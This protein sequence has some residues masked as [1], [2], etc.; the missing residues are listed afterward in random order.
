M[1]RVNSLSGSNIEVSHRLVRIFEILPGLATW[2]T[3]FLPI[4][5][6]IY[7]PVVV[8]YFIIAFDLF[9]L[10]KSFRMSSALLVGHRRLRIATQLDWV[11]RLKHLET[12]MDGGGVQEVEQAIVE[13]KREQSFF[14]YFSRVGRRKHEKLQQLQV[15]LD[16]LRNT[17]V[18]QKTIKPSDV[19]HVVI[20]ATYNET[21][22]TLRPSLEALAQVNYDLSKIWLVIAHEERGGDV[23]R[24]RIATLK[25]EFDGKFARLMS[26]EHP[27]GIVG[28]EKG[29]G[30]NI[31]YA[32][33]QVLKAIRKDKIN[34]K[35]VVITTLDADHRPDPEY[36]NHLTYSFVT[37][38]TPK[39]YSYQPIPMFFNNIWH[40]PAPMRVIAT[41]NSFW[42]IIN[43]VRPHL[44]RNFAS[45]SQPLEALVDT[46]FWATWSVVE[47]GH[48]YWRSYYRYN[49]QYR[50]EP[51]Y[52][53][54]YQD[55]TLASG[56]FKTFKNQYL[57]M[58]RWAYGVSDVPYVAIQNMRHPKIPK[59]SRTVHFW[60]LF[61]GHFSWATA[62][63][64][65]T[66]VA[67]MPLFLN[68]SFKYSVLAH[69]LP[70][71]ASQIMTIAMVGLFL[72]IWL[73]II[74]LPQRPKSKKKIHG[75]FMILQW[76]LLPIVALGFGALAA[77]DA[78]TR[79]M[80]GKYLGFRV[81]E[82][83]VKE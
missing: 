68:A 57:Q 48:Q 2:I 7:A 25:Q 49:G 34:I 54:I 77:I 11:A 43:S 29:K 67:W 44:L 62:P 23:D 73:S 59:S 55:A 78:Q 14:W 71:I 65:L 15:E 10:M 52:A 27:D 1:A 19:I 61:E 45:H 18:F 17:G 13:G 40:V 16:N 79:L 51:I 50:V 69:Q 31:T 30:A 39:H 58:R 22:E 72:T 26:F 5:L 83:A 82:K 42:V 46:D 36:F 28:E 32:G 75:L 33:R 35:S 81:T 74:S 37:S 63:L 70:I 76:A 3:I 9:W 4:V 24:E 20:L 8:A 12:M 66:F 60:R 47:D 53:P 38:E 56:Y 41:G 80:L 6:S 64:I 21:L